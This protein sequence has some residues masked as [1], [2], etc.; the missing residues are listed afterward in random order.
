MT[1]FSCKQQVKHKR[2]KAK[3]VLHQRLSR[4][5]SFDNYKYR[6]KYVKKKNPS[7]REMHSRVSPQWGKAIWVYQDGWPPS[8]DNS[9]IKQ[10]NADQ[11]FTETTEEMP[12]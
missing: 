2:V 6:N 10:R 1:S 7:L 4:K 11:S 5:K 12:P 3:T 9:A 8:K